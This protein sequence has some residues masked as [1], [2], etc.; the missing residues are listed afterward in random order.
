MTL[1]RQYWR[2]IE[3]ENLKGPLTGSARQSRPRFPAATR[4]GAD[5]GEEIPAEKVTA[6]IRALAEN[7]LKV[8]PVRFILR[9]QIPAGKKSL[10]FTLTFRAPDRTLQDEEV[11]DWHRRIVRHLEQEVGAELRA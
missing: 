1:A 2:Q 6:A 3:I 11:D 4:Y 10:A 9:K 8:A 7:F 5:H